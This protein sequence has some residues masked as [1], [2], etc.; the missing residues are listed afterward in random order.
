MPVART[1]DRVARG[2]SKSCKRSR[3]IKC[4]GA[5]LDHSLARTMYRLRVDTFACTRYNDLIRLELHTT[6][7]IGSSSSWMRGPSMM[8]YPEYDR[9]SSTRDSRILLTYVSAFSSY[10]THKA[11]SYRPFL[12]ARSLYRRSHHSATETYQPP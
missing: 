5:R 9:C 6:G 7:I 11:S 8:F 3:Q 4:F 1:W 10:S 12:Y 2:C